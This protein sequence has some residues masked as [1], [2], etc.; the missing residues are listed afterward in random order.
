GADSTPVESPLF[1]R[2]RAALLDALPA[3]P[4]H[5][6]LISNEVGMGIVP[7]GPLSRR[8]CDEAGRLHQDLARVCD[9]VILT[10]A[11]LPSMLKGDRS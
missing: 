11:G 10:V 4:G 9:R 5:I 7:L 3:L 8:F 2:E 1:V 6:I